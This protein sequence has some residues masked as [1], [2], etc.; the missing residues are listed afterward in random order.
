MKIT[1]ARST[2]S[3]ILNMFGKTIDDE[4][5]IIDNKTKERIQTLNGEEIHIE[6]FGGIRK[7]SEIFLKSDLPTYIEIADKIAK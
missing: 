4:D 7:G 1:F 3:I 5:Y 2:R 6:K